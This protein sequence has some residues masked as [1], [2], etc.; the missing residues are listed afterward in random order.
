MLRSTRFEEEPTK[1]K[2]AMRGGEGYGP[3]AKGKVE[4]SRPGESRERE[5][6]TAARSN[7]KPRRVCREP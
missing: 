1:S 5:R 6:D 3:A 2:T 7:K 4:M